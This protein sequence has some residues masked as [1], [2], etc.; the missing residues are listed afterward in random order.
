MVVAAKGPNKHMRA[1]PQEIGAL[2]VPGERGDQRELWPLSNK[3]NAH[4]DFY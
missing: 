3:M 1:T 4:Y 2:V